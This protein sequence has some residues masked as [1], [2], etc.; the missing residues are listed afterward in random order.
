MCLHVKFCENPQ[1]KFEFR[2]KTKKHFSNIIFAN[3]AHVKFKKASFNSNQDIKKNVTGDGD[4]TQNNM[5]RHFSK[6]GGR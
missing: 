2:K 6:T 5:S 3:I 1:N 4:G